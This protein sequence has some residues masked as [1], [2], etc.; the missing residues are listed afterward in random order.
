MSKKS[1]RTRSPLVSLPRS[2]AKRAMGPAV[3]LCAVASPDLARA[4]LQNG[5]IKGVVTSDLN[6]KPLPGV[7]VVVTGPALQGEQIEITDGNGRYLITEIPS[8]DDYVVRFYLGDKVEERSGI[9]ITHGKTL[10]VS[11]AFPIKQVARETKVIRE[12]APNVDTASAT[13]GVEINQEVLKN[14]AVRGRTFESVLAM[15]P[16]TV[17]PPR[18]QGGDIGVSISGS[19]GNENNFIIDGLNTSDP[20]TGIIGT[21]LHQYFIKEVNVITGGYQAEYGRAT[22]GVVSIITKGG[23]DELHGSV[24]LSMQP[25]QLTPKTV[26]RLGEAL[27]YRRKADGLLGDIGFELGGPI[28]KDK[29]WFYIGFAPTVAQYQTDRVI[30]HAIWNPQTGTARLNGGYACPTYLSDPALCRGSAALATEMD[31]VSAQSFTELRQLYNGIAKLQFNLSPDH[32]LTLS[33]IASPKVFSGYSYLGSGTSGNV[34]DSQYQ[35]TDQVHDASLRYVGKLLGRKLQLNAMYGF[36]FQGLNVAPKNVD[37]PLS[38][39]L[40]ESTNPYSL[41]DFEDNPDCR[42]QMQR[43]LMGNAVSFNPCPITTYRTNGFGQY[44]R[45]DL[46]RH[47]L[48]VAATYFL[49]ALGTHAIKLGFDFEHL[50]NQ[51]FRAYSGPN[52]DPSDGLSANVMYRTSADGQRLRNFAQYS[53]VG[54]NGETILLNSFS[55]DTFTNNY[56]LYLRDSWNVGPVPGLVLN[57]GV[58]WEAQDLHGSDGS[59]QIGIYDNWAPRA[60]AVW[61][62]TQKGLG[63]LFVNYGRFYQSIPLTINDRQFA[64]EGVFTGAET[65][66]CATAALQP[67]GRAVPVPR[68]NGTGT[69]NLSEIAAGNQ[70]GGRYGNVIPGLKGMYMDELVAGISYDVGWD[71]VLSASYIYRG[72]GNIVEDMSLDGGT[73]Y[74]IANPGVDPDPSRLRDLQADV[75]RL[76]ASGDSSQ[77]GQ[78]ALGRAQA[79][80][81]AYRSI[82]TQYPKPRREYQGLVLTAQK[83]L[84]NRFGLLAN[85]TYSRMLGNYPGTYDGVVDENLP[86]FSSQ[87]DL[88][89]MMK[90]RTGP[91]P[92]DRPHNVKIIGTYQQPIR[93]GNLTASLSFS[94]YSGRPINVLGTHFIYGDSQVFILPRGSGG[95]TPMVSQFDLHVGF[96]QPLSQKVNLSVY[97]DVINLFNQRAVTNVDDDYTY[98]NVAPIV[99][100]KI[101]DLAHLTDIDGHPIVKNA[102]Y[103][104][105]T[106][107]QAP[108]YLRLGARLSF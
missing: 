50:R 5:Q 17:D 41:A 69:C 60:G 62:F 86:N 29:I 18:G 66:D 2:L 84:S 26:G 90:N 52:G 100:G 30:R 4:Q 24:F 72:L 10:T 98:S 92:N 42:R 48:L 78:E 70:N 36:H 9:R 106:G 105:P 46:Q 25:F 40:T 8:G 104:Q 82:A 102:N 108:L 15:A 75:D 89:D 64:G 58:R 39:Y 67:G 19:T 80:L 51:N 73:N 12:R 99:D 53:T 57:A 49:E 97:A 35:Q 47:Q 45:T 16:G 88:Q 32:N 103:G 1:S 76:R 101:A 38:L 56:V 7:T 85:Y 54:P 21:E 28:K 13:A 33:Y 59:R 63:K 71:L 22:G 65:T 14:T 81:D 91:L 77:M 34:E 87:F 27:A 11:F 107:Y 43:D 74:I 93:K 37:K 20:N 68:T 6:G 3:I 95:R 44:N 23:G 96:E 83:R 79:R 94:A 31:E 55:S 61:D